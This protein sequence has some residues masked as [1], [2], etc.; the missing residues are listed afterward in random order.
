MTLWE[1]N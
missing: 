1:Y